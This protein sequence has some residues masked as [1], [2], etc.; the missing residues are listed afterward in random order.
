MKIK[1]L[2]LSFS[3]SLFA[4]FQLFAQQ[5]EDKVYKDH[6]Q[7]VRLFPAGVTFDASI[8]APVVPLRGGKP[9]VLVF[10]DL[11][12]DPEMY[13]A[14]LIHCDADWQKSQLKDN[15]FLLTF[16]EFNIQDYE[17][18]VNTR[19]PYIHYRFE[20]PSVTK[21]GNYIL[22]VYSQRDD[23]DVY[24][25]KRFMVYEE[26]FKVGASIVPPSQTS[27][28]SN[29]QQ[30]N[31]VVNYSAGEVTNPDGQIKVLIRQNQRWD[32]AKFLA[33][34]TFMNES[35]K[36]LRYESFDGGN[37]FDAGNEFRF[38]DLRFIRANGV[39]IANMR[40]EPDAIFADGN[41]NKPR[42]ETAYSQYLDLNGQYIIETKDRP[43]GNPEIESEYM[44]MTFRLAVP[45]NTDPIYLLGSLT[46]WGKTPEAKMK[47]DSKMGVYTTSLLVKQGWYDYQYAHLI[48]GEFD[49][50]PF[51]GSY[52]ETENEYEVLVYFRNLGSRYDRLV[53]YIYLHPNRRRL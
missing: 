42:P 21:S 23:S 45:E 31:V 14:K 47:W 5:L 41:I 39:N 35:S 15:D 18:S 11:A 49:P 3:L 17:Y 51:E 24:L 44:L 4:I 30:I 37:T 43:G 34:P 7:S 36:I 22:Q 50:N 26:V 1:S 6:I 40:V 27:D 48:N 12:F 29:S 33:K 8:D 52:F 13:R 32:N 53:G 2:L 20:L 25:T 16:N 9:L 46:N 38:V 10:D 19:I 28:R